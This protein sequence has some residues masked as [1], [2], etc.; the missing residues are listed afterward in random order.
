MRSDQLD[1]KR[2]RLCVIFICPL[3]GER[4]PCQGQGVT[5]CREPSVKMARWGFLAAELCAYSRFSMQIRNEL[6]MSGV[7]L[8]RLALS[9]LHRNKRT[10][11]LANNETQDDRQ[12]CQDQ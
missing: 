2:S 11:G 10:S 5:M 9:P 6:F 4:S 1:V 12:A 8:S 3:A 7:V